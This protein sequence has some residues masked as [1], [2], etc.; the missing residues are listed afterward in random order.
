[1]TLVVESVHLFTDINSTCIL[2][3]SLHVTKL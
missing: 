3:E 1:M 2:Y